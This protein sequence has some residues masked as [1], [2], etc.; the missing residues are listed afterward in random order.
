MLT[1]LDWDGAP[2][3]LDFPESFIDKAT[4]PPR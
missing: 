4:P 1:P 3:Y 2:L